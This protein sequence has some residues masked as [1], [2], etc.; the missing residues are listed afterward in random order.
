MATRNM[1]YDRGLLPVSRIQVPVVSIGNLTT[2][3]TGKTPVVAWS[4]TELKRLGMQ[5]GILS[6]GYQAFSDQENDEKRVL[7]LLCPGT[8]HILQRDRIAGARQLV[9]VHGV[10]SIV[11]DDAFQHR[12]LHR[13]VDIVLLDAL[14]AWGFGRLLP[15]GLL[16]ESVKSIRRAHAVILTRCDAVTPHAVSHL[17]TEIRA[18]TQ[19]PALQTRFQVLGLRSTTGEFIPVSNMLLQGRK[20]AAFCGI[21]N[22]DGFRRTLQSLTG[23]DMPLTVFPDHHHYSQTEWDALNASH[24]PDLWLTTLKDLVKVQHL[25]LGESSIFAVEIGLEFLDDPLPVRELLRQA[26]NQKP[27]G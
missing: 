21:G 5:P 20:F 23:A 26:A 22:P 16:R 12:R 7:D 4:I 9:G 11:L 25:D 18:L 8:P 3:G 10:N 19:V 1:L 13:D 14:N 15:R 27:L 6:R 2:G 24:Q 17:L